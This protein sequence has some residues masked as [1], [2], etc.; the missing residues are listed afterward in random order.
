MSRESDTLTIIRDSGE[1]QVTVLSAT[2]LYSSGRS[3]RSGT[4]AVWTGT[5]LVFPQRGTF[6]R[7]SNGEVK[8]STHMAYM[9]LSS[10]VAVGNQILETGETEYFL[11]E[12]VKTWEDHREVQC[13]FVEGR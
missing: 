7:A 5:C 8:E 12:V 9:P 1:K 3:H 10:T 6:V 11:A 13:N 2:V 4:T